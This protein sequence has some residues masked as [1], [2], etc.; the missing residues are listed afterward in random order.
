MP[1]G[2]RRFR[3]LFENKGLTRYGGLSLFQSFCRSFAIRRFLQKA[4][5]WPDY[6]HRGYHPADIFLTHIISIVA[7]IGRVENTQ[8]L[9]YNGLIPP[10]LGLH[11]FPHRDTLREFL[12]RFGPKEFAQLQIAHDRLRRELFNRLKLQY[13]AIVDADTTALLTYGTQEGVMRGYVPK[14]H[15]GQG[16]YAPIISSEGRTGLSLG[17]QLRA[18]NIPAGHGAPEFLSVHRKRSPTWQNSSTS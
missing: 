2:P 6:D 7:G 11:T 3:F 13:S 1:K 10:L 8:S 16:S 5:R 15:H 12:R 14:Q 17:M 4:V 18:G 9:T